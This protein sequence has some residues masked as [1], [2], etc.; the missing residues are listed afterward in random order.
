MTYFH[1]DSYYYNIDVNPKP[2]VK[3]Q[4]QDLP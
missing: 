3:L 1:F 2:H 4:D